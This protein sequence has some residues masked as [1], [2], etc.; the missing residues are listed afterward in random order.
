MTAASR[1][2]KNIV[3]RILYH[4]RQ[5]DMV[6]EVVLRILGRRLNGVFLDMEL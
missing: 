2:V 1:H 6:A 4:L 5:P 3:G